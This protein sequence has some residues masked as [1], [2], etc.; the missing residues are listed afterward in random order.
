MGPDGVGDSLAA[1]IF[2]LSPAWQHSHLMLSLCEDQSYQTY[3]IQNHYGNKALGLSVR[4]Y[5]D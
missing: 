4:D 2:P 3:R 1:P 5:P